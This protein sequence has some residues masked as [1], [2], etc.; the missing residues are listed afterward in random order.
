MPGGGGGFTDALMAQMKS[1]PMMAMLLGKSM[2][3]N[4]RYGPQ[5]EPPMPNPQPK[6]M[7]SMAPWGGTTMPSPISPATMGN[8]STGG[9]MH[10]LLRMLQLLQGR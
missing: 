4:P 10:N 7:G 2:I 1:N 5:G 9:D 8:A 6:P 3:G